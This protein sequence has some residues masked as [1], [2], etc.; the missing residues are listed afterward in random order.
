MSITI[1]LANLND[2]IDREKYA[3]EIIVKKDYSDLESIKKYINNKYNLKIDIIISND[4]IIS[5]LDD[6][7][8]DLLFIETKKHLTPVTP[9]IDN[10]FN[11]LINNILQNVNSNTNI[12]EDEND[13]ESDLENNDNSNNNLFQQNN[14]DNSIYSLPNT[15][16]F[17][18]SDKLLELNNIGFYNNSLNREALI[19]TNGNINQAINYILEN[20]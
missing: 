19:V 20:N 13:E 1:Y 15:E 18:F 10:V 14:I 12:V 6:D 7:I 4:K 2:L 11:N 9:S 17:E 16:D 3:T 8:E 5:T